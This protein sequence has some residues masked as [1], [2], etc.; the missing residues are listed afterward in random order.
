MVA[1]WVDDPTFS[2]GGIS[3][4]RRGFGGAGAAD[5]SEWLIESPAGISCHAD[6]FAADC[7]DP[8]TGNPG[9]HDLFY[10]AG[11]GV[12]FFAPGIGDPADAS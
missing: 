1:G 6:T 5:W 8:G 4:C 12:P 10:P 3:R 9:S 7:F 11:G 2:A